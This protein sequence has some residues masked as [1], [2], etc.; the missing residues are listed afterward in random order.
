MAAFLSTSTAPFVVST[1]TAED[2]RT[3]EGRVRSAERFLLVSEIMVSGESNRFFSR[4]GEMF[5]ILRTTWVDGAAHVYYTEAPAAAAP[6]IW[7]GEM[8]R[9]TMLH[10]HPFLGEFEA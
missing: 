9:R 3:F 8:N 5:K 2:G 6:H 1:R 7:G 10:T 4:D